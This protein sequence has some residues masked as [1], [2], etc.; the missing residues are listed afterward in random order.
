[1]KKMLLL[2]AVMFAAVTFSACSDDDN[3]GEKN[4]IIG[5]WE[6]THLTGY[7]NGVFTARLS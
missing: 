7:D 3:K 6:Y 4:S 5:K 2:A 1:M